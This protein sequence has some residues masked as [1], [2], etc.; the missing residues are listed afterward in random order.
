MDFIKNFFENAYEIITLSQN[1]KKNGNND[2]SSQVE[3]IENLSRISLFKAIP[4]NKLF[5][6]YNVACEIEL[7]EGA[8]LFHEGDAANEFYVILEGSLAVMK[9]T[10]QEK[11]YVLSVLEEDQTIGE[12]GLIDHAPRSASVKSIVSTKLLRINFDELNDLV[13]KDPVFDQI[14]KHISVDITQRLR[15]TNEITVNALE[16][17]INEYKLRVATGIFMMY[18]I[19][20]ISIFV[21]ALSGLQYLVHHISNSSFISLPF[22]FIVVCVFLLELKVT[23]LP[24]ALFGFTFKNARKALIESFFYSLIFCCFILL[25]KWIEIL[26]F[27]SFA[28]RSLFEPFALI[29]GTASHSKYFMWVI[30]LILYCFFISPLQEVMCRGAFQGSLDIFLVGRYKKVLSILISN[31]LFSMFHIF[32][33]FQLAVLV[34][35]PGIFWGWLFSRHKTLVG[36]CLS[37]M[38]LGFWALW[39]VGIM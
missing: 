18:I 37:H 16:K 25:L 7:P 23:K 26:V 21:F 39:V 28:G 24:A 30:T 17:Q 4:K 5:L 11:E 14:F 34:F 33:S 32:V 13:K 1:E 12:M 6:L 9:T 38:M 8:Y 2:N 15:D 36:V 19:S 20:G 35:I 29:H 31:L 10:K 27:P 22:M 3:K